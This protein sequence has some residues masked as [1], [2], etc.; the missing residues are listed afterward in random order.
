MKQG[1]RLSRSSSSTRSVVPRHLSEQTVYSELIAAKYV[2]ND[3]WEWEQITTPLLTTAPFSAIPPNGSFDCLDPIAVGAG[4]GT[5]VS[6]SIIVTHVLFSGVMYFPPLTPG[7]LLRVALVQH[8]RGALYISGFNTSTILS[9]ST[10]SSILS[11]PFDRNW[12]LSTTDLWSEICFVADLK[13]LHVNFDAT[14]YSAS[15]QLALYV[16]ASNPTASFTG[17]NLT[18]KYIN[19]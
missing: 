5:R 10:N 18:V 8:F 2:K 9:P 6:N 7:A 17:G 19:V 16:Y 1:K 14:A 11:V 12:T 15:S 3:T 4:E 13:R